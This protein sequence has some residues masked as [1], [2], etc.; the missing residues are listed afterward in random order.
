M[1]ITITVIS[2]LAIATLVWLVNRVMSFNVCPICTGVFLTWVWLIIAHT[3]G[4]QVN[5]IIPAL[6]MG[7]TVVGI[8]YKIEK[9]FSGLS[10]NKM[11]LWKILFVPAG[12][13]AAYALLEQSEIVF[14]IAIAFLFLVSFIL[15]HS[16]SSTT[17]S[18]PET[19]G[20]IEKKMED[21]C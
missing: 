6:L 15:L 7:G 13:V 17:G 19:V 16:K 12:F 5:L 9:K 2:I 18:R 11:L 14:I 4:Y 1:T 20:D 3:I 21:C 10:A 8:M